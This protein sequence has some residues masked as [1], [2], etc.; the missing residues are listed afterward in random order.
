MKVLFVDLDGTIRETRS[1]E[2]FINKATDQQP[3]AGAK[4]AIAHFAS[5]AKSISAWH[6]SGECD[7]RTSEIFRRTVISKLFKT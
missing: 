7:T 4:K 6:P 1:G 5:M 3:I 2:T